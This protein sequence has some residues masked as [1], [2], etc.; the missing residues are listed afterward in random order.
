MLIKYLFVWFLLA[1]VMILNGIVRQATYGKHVPDLTAHQVSTLTAIL[2]AGAVVWLAHRAWP[3]ATSSQAWSIG[4]F[5]LFLTIAFEFGFGRFVAGH[6][7]DRLLADYN[8]F[9]GRVWSVFLLWL[10]VLPYLVFKFAPR[11]VA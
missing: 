5:W 9:N 11:T 6:P 2:L 1:A 3:V 7:W 8:I 10:T 4:F